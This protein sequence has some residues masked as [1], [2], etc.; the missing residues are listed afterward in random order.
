MLVIQNVRL[1]NP[2]TG[3]DGCVD[4]YEKD[5]LIEK[6][7]Q[8][9]T[10]RSE[11]DCTDREIIDAAG[12]VAFPGLIDVHTHFRD[13][14]F[15]YKEDIL[16]GAKA[17]AKGGYTT[18]IMMCNTSPAIDCP[19]VLRE[20]LKK[21]EECE[22]RVLSCGA[23]TKGL[24]GKE[25][26]D[27]QVL[28]DAGAVGFTDD[29][30]PILDRELLRIAFERSA[31]LSVPVSLH[32]E[33]ASLIT[34]NG[35]NRG[36]ASAHFGIGGSPREAEITMIEKDLQVA[37]ET[38]AIV[39]IQ[40]IST[41]EGVELVRKAKA[42]P[43]N[44]VHAEATPHHILLT[45]EDVI[46]AGTLAKVNPPIRTEADRQAILAGLKDGTIDIIATDHAPHAAE[47]KSK[48]VTE[49]PS[50]MIGLET[51]L[52]IALE[53]LAKEAGMDLM[54]I[55]GKFSVAPA[56]L[57]GLDLGDVSAGKQADLVLFHPT[58]T[59]VAEE[60]VSKSSNCPFKGRK[61]TGRIHYTIC[62][63]KVVYRAE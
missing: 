62:G 27:M 37:L 54:E 5:G 17:A 36:A 47:E 52:S 40:H 55:A 45:E 28:L 33:D 56:E 35:I 13:P 11:E 7:L 24:K 22:I 23:V 14:G 30:I 3:F 25:L 42:V 50:G 53:V 12:L 19:E 57:Y 38:G 59:W 31:A 43:G 16:T 49:A 58:E 63:G 15:T 1:V 46:A 51:A 44:R 26:T 18:V 2:A 29:G 6:I 39:N 61:M 9:G 32:E 4:I 48:P 41:K 21:A 10:E 60:F 34:N 20:C 8:A